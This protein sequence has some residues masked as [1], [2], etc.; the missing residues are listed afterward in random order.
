MG[1]IGVRKSDLI[2]ISRVTARYII[3]IELALNIKT[4]GCVHKVELVGSGLCPEHVKPPYSSHGADTNA[5]DKSFFKR[6]TNP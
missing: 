1:L 4:P 2:F 3:V 6:I 5:D